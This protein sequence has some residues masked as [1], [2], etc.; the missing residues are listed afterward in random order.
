MLDFACQWSPYGGAPAGEIWV[1]FGMTPDR[2]YEHV[3]RILDSPA[4]H[5][6]A[7]PVHRRVDQLAS[8]T[9]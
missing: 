4:A 6:F 2:F 9:N 7:P 1:E 5:A 3:Q 8:S